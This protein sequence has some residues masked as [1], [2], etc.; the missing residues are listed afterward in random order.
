MKK[1][2]LIL[3]L[4][5]GM[6]MP[7]YAANFVEISKYED[8]LIDADSIEARTSGNHEYV[9]A[10]MKMTPRED[11]VRELSS[12][13]KKTVDYAIIFVAF[14]E[15]RRQIQVLL[16]DLYDKKGNVIDSY[17]HPFKMSEYK[18]VAPDSLGETIYDF[19]MYYY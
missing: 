18:E 17:S 11:T 8:C 9:V 2:A 5:F 19:V 4:L 15:N 14:N 12:E 13:Y 16:A 6:C 10:S 1:I 7:V 3:F